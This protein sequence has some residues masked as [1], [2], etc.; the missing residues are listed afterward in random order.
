MRKHIWG[1]LLVPLLGLGAG[2]A[3]TKPPPPLPA[4]V[5]ATPLQRQISDWDEYVGR[6]EAT[7]T[8]EIRP[9]VTGYVLKVAFKDGQIVRRGQLLFQIDPRP[10]QAALNQAAAQQARASAT[11]QE[12]Q[13]E[14]NRSRALLA[15]K[16]TSQ[17]DL[18][19]R[20]AAVLQG[21]ADVR[22][23][24]AVVATARLNLGF[25]RVIAPIGGRVSDSHAQ[26][27]ALVTQDSTV[28]TDVV[29][30]DPIRFAFQAPEDLLLKYQRSRGG[31]GAPV[32]IRLQDE[33]G[34]RWN[35]R[36][37][38][39]DNALDAG[40]GTIRAYALAPNH[41]GFL[42][43]GMFGHMRLLSSSPHSALLVPDQAVVTDLSRQLVLVVTPAG[44]VAQRPV[45]LG[46]IV[47]GLRVVRSG[48]S[49]TDKV[50][51]SGVQHAHAGD[52]V[53]VI[54]GRTTPEPAL[55]AAAGA[56]TATP[57]GSATFA[58]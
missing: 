51:I 13:V 2:C 26:P 46:P 53:R 40:S 32:Q 3:K 28:M 30:L 27:G 16:A 19:T 33:A 49:L 18:D 21:Q 5:V 37:A 36:I 55:A 58:Q 9:R 42:K 57:A 50:I 22:A 35:G 7:N 45:Q 56:E 12:A 41:E 39:V 25:T 23:A 48:L 43:P 52:K 8:V 17:Q 4:V 47:E 1:L 34:Y 14:L 44:V 24:Q 6:F 29:A 38:F 31:A 54:S 10:Y 20:L 15:A 11:L